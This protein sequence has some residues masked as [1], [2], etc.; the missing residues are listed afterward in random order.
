M[1]TAVPFGVVTDTLPELLTVGTVV[2]ILVEVAEVTVAFVMLSLVLLLEAVVWKF[3]PLIVRLVPVVPVVG[4][5]LLI[6][7]ALEL[8]TVNEVLLETETAETV[9]WIT[10]VVAPLGTVVTICVAVE[11]VTVAAVPLNVTVLL[12]GVV[13]K[14]V[15]K[16]VTVVPIGPLFG[17]KPIN[18]NVAELAR[19]IDSTLPT[20]S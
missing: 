10:P 16:I 13:L 7:G 20:A 6:V 15:P 2:E 5:R 12:A 8:V 1:L 11:E 18:D 17:L 3:V 9:T 19:E 4:E 14:A